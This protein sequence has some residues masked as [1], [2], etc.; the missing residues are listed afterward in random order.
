MFNRPGPCKSPWVVPGW[1]VWMHPALSG[2]RAC[3]VAEEKARAGGEGP[4][5][6]LNLGRSPL[7]KQSLTGFIVGGTRIPIKDCEYKGERPNPTLNPE[8]LLTLE[9]LKGRACV[10]RPMK[11]T[12]AKPRFQEP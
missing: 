3:G 2:S 1:V 7:Y 5:S 10:I 9:L 4:C 12:P 11:I 6:P 8:P